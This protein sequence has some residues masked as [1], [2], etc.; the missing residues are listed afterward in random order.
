MEDWP[1]KGEAGEA[2]VAIWFA[3]KMGLI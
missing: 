1:E 2:L 3:K